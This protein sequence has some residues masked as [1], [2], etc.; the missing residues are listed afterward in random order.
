M[1]DFKDFPSTLEGE[2]FLEKT[3]DASGNFSGWLTVKLDVALNMIGKSDE[4]LEQAGWLKYKNILDDIKA[5]EDEYISKVNEIKTYPKT[6][7][8]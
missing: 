1:V 8:T 4:E 6:T 2:I 5:K 7:K 3:C